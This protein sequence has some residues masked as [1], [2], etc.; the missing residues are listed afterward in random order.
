V[1]LEQFF[2]KGD[3]RTDPLYEDEEPIPGKKDTFC[4]GL[5]I[6]SKDH[7]EPILKDTVIKIN[8]SVK[9]RKTRGNS[10]S[11]IHSNLSQMFKKSLIE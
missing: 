4:Q 2:N 11:K 3:Q 8:D 6:D 9:R 7:P 10:I 1:G 5:K